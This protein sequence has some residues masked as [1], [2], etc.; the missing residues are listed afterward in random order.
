MPQR[1]SV[2]FLSYSDEPRPTARETLVVRRLGR[3]A[4]A[5]W[6]AAIY[7][8]YWLAQVGLGVARVSGR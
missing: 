2:S 4:L 5:A 3:V 8:V 7:L 6:A 1:P